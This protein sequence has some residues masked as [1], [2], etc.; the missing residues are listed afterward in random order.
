MCL[1]HGQHD[2]RCRRTQAVPGREP[3]RLYGTHGLHAARRDAADTQRK[4]E[5]QSTATTRG[6][7]RRD[8][9]SRNRTGKEDFRYR[10]HF[11]EAQSV[12]CHEQPHLHGSD[13]TDSHAPEC[14]YPAAVRTG[15]TN[16]GHPADTSHPFAD[17]IGRQR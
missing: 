5:H 7:G 9:C 15:H 3:D 6:E 10:F 14:R 12:W 11:I 17:T 8:G 4:G 16:Q 2:Y 13:V 1:L